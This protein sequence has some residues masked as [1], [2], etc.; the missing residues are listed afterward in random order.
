MGK[1][2]IAL[3]CALFLLSI[4]SLLAQNQTITLGKD[5][6]WGDLEEKSNLVTKPGWQGYMDLSLGPDEY[7]VDQ[8]TDL[9]LHFDSTSVRDASGRWS[10]VKSGISTRTSI[11]RMGRGAA[12]FT[13][14][15]GGIELSAPPDSLFG[16]GNTSGSFSIEFWLYSVGGQ[17]GNTVLRWTGARSLNGKPVSQEVSIDISDDRLSFR[18]VNFFISASDSPET[19]SLRG[20]QHQI[21]RTWHH[22]LIRYNRST[23]LIEY[24]VDGQPEAVTYA[25]STGHEGGNV[26]VPYAGRLSNGHLFLGPEL[27]GMMDEFRI[28][29][30]VVDSPHLDVVSDTRGVAVSKVFSLQYAGS[31]LATITAQYATPGETAILFF[32][33]MGDR[34]NGSKILDAQWTP[35]VPGTDFLR[36][37]KPIRGRFIQVRAELLPD[38]PHLDS[39]SLGSVVISYV[40]DLPPPPPVRVTARAGNGEVTLQWSSL[41]HSSIKGYLVYYGDRPG[42]YFGTGIP[43]GA[44][45]IDVGN[46]TSITLKGLSNGKLYYFVVSAYDES[47]VNHASA[48]SQEVSARPLRVY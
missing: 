48:L 29:K 16:P 18:F 17:D 15:S 3:P 28:E 27:T 37:G 9:L 30:R 33:R 4:G 22:H 34:S 12:V 2:A 42:Q 11:P 41:P 5:T 1:R 24:L 10:V 19:V 46:V 20:V 26:Y 44:S 8:D 31:R 36:D 14:G 35:F 25:T 39:P 13:A 43:D 40:P 6:G 23:G 47:G 45:P 21:P 32:Y 7:A 38:G